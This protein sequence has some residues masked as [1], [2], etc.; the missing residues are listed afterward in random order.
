MAATQPEHADDPAPS[1]HEQIVAVI[2]GLIAAGEY[3]VGDQLPSERE[4]A[5]SF[6]TSRN[7]VR[8]AIVLLQSR[9]LLSKETK[10]RARVTQPNSGDMLNQLINA[11][12]ALYSTTDDVANLQEARALFECGL[13]RYAARH[14]SPK[15]IERLEFALHENR[16][17]I[18]DPAAFVET[19]LA[20]HRIIV[21]I[22]DNPLFLALH[23]AFEQWL[24]SQR[25]VGI[26]ARGSAQAVY[27]DH[28][29]IFAGISA[30]DPEAAEAAM[31]E[32][33]AK[34]VRFYWKATTGER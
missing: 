18:D 15:Q 13:V 32:H 14:A 4:L 29:R 31:A 5:A 3:A 6:Q 17:A 28:E 8:E 19:D 16:L 22:P 23:N 7:T 10:A 33:L 1:A 25:K 11:A 26:G 24:T 21:Q 2:E 30:H 20:F 27:A 12:R 34:G 9:G